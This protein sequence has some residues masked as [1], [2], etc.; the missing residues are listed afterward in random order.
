MKTFNTGKV[1]FEYPTSWEVEKADILSNPD[2]IATLSKGQDNLINAVMFPTATNLE[3][4]KIFMEDA[5]SDDGGVILAS[6]FV[7]IAGMDAIK[8][9]ANMDTPEINFDI[10]TYV[11]IEN[12]EIFIFEMRTLDVSGESESEFKDIISSFKILK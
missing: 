3:D 9:H 4:Y 1:S 11:F 6:D 7:E 12:G 8:L 10:H 5:L 2:C